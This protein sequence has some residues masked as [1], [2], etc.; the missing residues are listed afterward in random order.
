MR[1]LSFKRLF[2]SSSSVLN[3]RM[4][5]E[6]LVK[7]YCEHD[8]SNAISVVTYQTNYKSKVFLNQKS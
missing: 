6:Y 2:V 1:S 4:F 3:N 5:S 8:D 7:D